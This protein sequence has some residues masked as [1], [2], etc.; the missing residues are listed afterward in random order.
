MHTLHKSATKPLRYI[1][2]DDVLVF[3]TASL[4][5]CR[6]LVRGSWL[7]GT[8]KRQRT[9]LGKGDNPAMDTTDFEDFLVGYVDSTD[10]VVLLGR[11]RWSRGG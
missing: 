5:Q 9:S 7:R 1:C 2:I 3:M 11:K 8:R 6:P 4:R 10:F